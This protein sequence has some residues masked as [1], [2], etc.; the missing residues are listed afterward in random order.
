MLGFL[1]R[2]IPFL[3]AAVALQI[4]WVWWQIDEPPAWSIVGP[5]ESVTIL[6]ATVRPEPVG[7]GTTRYVPVVEVAPQSTPAEVFELAGLRGAFS[8]GTES[9]AE[10]ALRHF[11]PGTEQRARVI[12]GTYY[13]DRTNIAGLIISIMTSLIGLFALLIGIRITFPQR[14]R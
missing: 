5:R 8:S 13:A 3:I 10:R 6:A 4:S 1:L 14:Q 11:P 12:D 2:G 9:E 7:N